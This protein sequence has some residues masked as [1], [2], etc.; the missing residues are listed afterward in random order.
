[1]TEEQDY[2]RGGFCKCRYERVIKH[3]GGG[4]FPHHQ[5]IVDVERVTDPTCPIHGTVEK[6]NAEPP[7]FWMGGPCNGD[8][9]EGLHHDDEGRF[10][11]PVEKETER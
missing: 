9:R 7:R 3:I 10:W 6:C 4:L 5:D 8:H 2:D 11:G 1:M